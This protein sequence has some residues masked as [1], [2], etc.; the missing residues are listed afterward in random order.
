M[1]YSGFMVLFDEERRAEVVKEIG[2]V[3][4]GFSDTFSSADWGFKA[5]EVCLLSFDGTSIACACLAVRGKKVA[6]GK[7]KVNFSEF[8]LLNEITIRQIRGRL[9]E[10]LKKHFLK[11][12]TGRGSRLPEK[13]W[14]ETI[15]AIKTLRRGRAEAIDRLLQ[16]RS[17]SIAPIVEDW[18]QQVSE[19]RDACGL[20]LDVFDKTHM[21]RQKA[22]RTWVPSKGPGA[23]FLAGMDAIKLTEEQMLANDAKYFPAAEIRENALGAQFK[24]GDRVLDVL[25]LNRTAVENSIGVDLIYYN[26]N[27]K[28]YT[29][30][31]YK[32]MQEE[33]VNA[34]KTYVYRPS[35]DSNFGLELDRMKKFRKANPD[36][37]AMP[38]SW[39][40]YRLCGD[41]FFFK[42]CPATV[43]EVLSQE[44]IGG[45]YLPREYMESLLVSNV[46]SGERGG[47]LLTFDNTQR[48]LSNTSFAQ[49]VQDGWVGTRDIP[50]SKI[51]A[52]IR[53]SLGARRAVV[54]AATHEAEPL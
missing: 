44:L 33:Q 39:D 37:W 6:T 12:S 18:A 7:Y 4:G 17:R 35:S 38:K 46:T 10:N 20:I 14:D 53:A 24:I 16:L 48:H 11:S 25:Y 2:D 54:A 23:P 31:Q 9:T 52:L 49:M 41:G 32:R 21:L 8:V 29:L 42:F 43:L 15:R 27:F 51:T 30:I 5:W 19:E 28:S 50:T 36:S 1:N 34:R 22:L 47:K 26:H 13:T 3:Y 45:M 40:T